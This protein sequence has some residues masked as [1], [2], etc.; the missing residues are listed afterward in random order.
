MC[1]V[2]VLH[3]GYSFVN[4]DGEMIANCSCTLIKGPHNIIIDTMTPWDSEV[5]LTAL[6]EHQITP[7][8]INFVVSTHGHSDHTGNNNLFLKATH[9]V[10]FS[11][12]FKDK[13]YIHPFEKGEEY[14]INDF[15]KIIPTPGHTL[16]DVTVLVKS[17]EENIAIVAGSED[18]I[19]QVKN[20]TMIA[21][22][23]NWI[24]P[25]HG[26]KFEVTDEMRMLLK[27]QTTLGA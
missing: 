9:I 18:P 7:D 12:S 27:N 21:D 24:I 23:A 17:E 26:P 8:D 22:I 15:V 5:I 1:E 6:K 14:V 16:S 4:N 19:K 11:I 2:V 20:R 25:G 10:G 3:D 13:Y